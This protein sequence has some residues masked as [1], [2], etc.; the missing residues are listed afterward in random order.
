[1]IPI[2]AAA[3]TQAHSIR[4]I[5]DG[6]CGPSNCFEEGVAEHERGDG[7]D[8]EFVFEDDEAGGFVEGQ[9]VK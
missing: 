6:H 1:L 4:G 5:G 3:R 2:R 7:V 8:G 9:G